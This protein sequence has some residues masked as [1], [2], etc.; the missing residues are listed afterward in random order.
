MT[1]EEKFD[2]KKNSVALFFIIVVIIIVVLAIDWVFTFFK[3]RI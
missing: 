2:P 1:E 3:E